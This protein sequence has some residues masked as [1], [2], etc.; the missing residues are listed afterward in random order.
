MLGACALGHLQRLDAIVLDA[1]FSLEI[2]RAAA[3]ILGK[4]ERIA[5]ILVGASP[6]SVWLASQVNSGRVLILDHDT[7]PDGVVGAIYS[8]VERASAGASNGGTPPREQSNG[9][10]GNQPEVG[11]LEAILSAREWEI[12]G[13]MARGHTDKEIARQLVLS[14]HTV[15]GHVRNVL[16]KLN[17]QNR[18]AAAAA[19]I[20]LV[21]GS[22]AGSAVG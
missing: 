18:T 4:L 3:S 17:V 2:A 15:K 21:S 11:Q 10:E 12:L 13:L 5:V 14:R 9:A 19:F 7:S 22:T 20:A 16:R 6:A 1:N 8:S